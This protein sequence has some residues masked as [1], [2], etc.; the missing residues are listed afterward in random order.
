MQEAIS[1]YGYI[2]LTT[3]IV[4]GKIYVGQHKASVFDSKY[5]GSGVHLRNAVAK[6]GKESFIVEMIDT[7]EN[8]EELSEKEIRWISKLDSRN[9]DIGYNLSKGGVGHP[10]SGDSRKRM[11]EARKR[12]CATEEAKRKLSALR[13]G[14]KMPEEAKKKISKANKGRIKSEEERRK[15]SKALKGNRAG[16]CSPD[17]VH[18][19][20]TDETRKKLSESHRGHKH[21]QETRR[22]MSEAHRRRRKII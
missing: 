16:F 21:S 2:Y 20:V 5:K 9:A 10:M 22:K 19:E 12:Y 15:L 1:M 13:L 11:S 4:N 18:K 8:K 7:A 14:K 17:Y 6:Y 3:N